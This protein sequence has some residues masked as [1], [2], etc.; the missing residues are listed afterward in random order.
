MVPK[1]IIKEGISVMIVPMTLAYSLKY[2][3][4]LVC[5][6]KAVYILGCG[7]ILEYVGVLVYNCHRYD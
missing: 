7:I 6:S 3:K 4:Y 2:Y 5:T 1:K